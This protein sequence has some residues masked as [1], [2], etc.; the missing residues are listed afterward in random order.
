MET[1]TLHTAKTLEKLSRK[2]KRYELV[3]GNLIEM[4]PAGFEHGGTTMTLSAYATLFVIQHRLGRC[5]A[6][7]TG[8][9]L[10]EDPDKVLAP[11]WAFISSDRLPKKRVRSYL[12]VVPDLVLETKSPGDSEREIIDKVDDWL[13]AGVKVVWVM[14]PI[15]KTITI[16]A[17]DTN[18]ILLNQT[19]TLTGGDLLPGFTLPL[20]S[21]FE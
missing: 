5:T 3:R 15:K 9:L 13:Q 18:P 7:E 11:D 8:F 16:Y 14:N 4:S 21:I 2:G 12:P 6:A 19:D 17:D 1:L 20:A 10:E